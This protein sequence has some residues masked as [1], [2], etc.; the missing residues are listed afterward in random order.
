MTS[1]E[2]A[3]NS[4]LFLLC[5]EIAKKEEQLIKLQASIDASFTREQF[6]EVVNRELK[7]NDQVHML[8]RQVRELEKQLAEALKRARRRRQ[9][10][11]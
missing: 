1:L 11:V 7:A 2:Q 6:N 5:Q 8:E 9:V 3:Y 10:G 4:L